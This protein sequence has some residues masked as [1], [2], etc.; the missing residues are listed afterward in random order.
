MF[1]NCAAHINNTASQCA[2]LATIPE[3]WRQPVSTAFQ[4]SVDNASGASRIHCS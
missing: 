1:W 4:L 2:A 3:Y